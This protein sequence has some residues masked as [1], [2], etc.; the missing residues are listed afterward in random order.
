M[1]KTDFNEATEQLTKRLKSDEKLHSAI[2]V[3]PPFADGYW[4]ASPKIVFCN[5]ENYGY[6]ND[7]YKGQKVILNFNEFFLWISGYWLKENLTFDQF[8]YRTKECT[9]FIPKE[10]KEKKSKPNKTAK[11]SLIFVNALIEKLNNIETNIQNIKKFSATKLCLSM[12]QLTYMN[13]RPTSGSDV[14]QDL[15]NT[16]Y[17]VSNYH[18]NI[19]RIILSLEA[20]IFILSSKDAANLFNNYL[21]KDE[22]QTKNAEALRF[23]GYSKIGNTHFFSIMHPS[24]KGFTDNYFNETINF[25]SSK[26]RGV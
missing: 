5:Y 1:S 3:Y 16:Q 15:F 20:D 6:D 17:W 12:N 14:R 11:K 25:I 10:D 8:Y 9:Q 18:E 22:I 2:M 13:L 24:Y 21:F 26:Y 19:K 23:K 4:S 7:K